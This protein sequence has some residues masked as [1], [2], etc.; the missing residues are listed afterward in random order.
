GDD[1]LDRHPQRCGED[2][3]L[4]RDAHPPDDQ[5]DGGDIDERQR[6]LRDRDIDDAVHARSTP[7]VV[8]TRPASIPTR[9]S[10]TASASGRECV[11]MTTVTPRSRAA[12]ATRPV[13][14]RSVP[15]ASADDRSSS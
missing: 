14:A 7:F 1:E 15:S 11:T 3:H 5:D 13:T 2:L 10:A 8:T 4:S 9:W 12:S 6:Q